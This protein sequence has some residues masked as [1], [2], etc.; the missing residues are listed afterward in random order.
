[1]NTVLWTTFFVAKITAT[2][3]APTQE[4]SYACM[5]TYIHPRSSH[6]SGWDI[7]GPT[8]E[9]MWTVGPLKCWTLLRSCCYCLQKRVVFTIAWTSDPTPRLYSWTGNQ[10]NWP[11][12]EGYTSYTNTNVACS[13]K[14]L[15]SGALNTLITKLHFISEK[16]HKKK[17]IYTFF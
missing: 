4:R 9:T 5:K 13:I 10:K 17:N 3:L 16:Q 2:L 7:P 14:I 6:L 11:T 1:M 15:H 12:H 8:V